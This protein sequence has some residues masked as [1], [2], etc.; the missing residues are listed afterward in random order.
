MNSEVESLDINLYKFLSIDAHHFITH[1]KGTPRITL[2]ESSISLDESH[3]FPSGA[4]NLLGTF[5][6]AT[7]GTLSL[8]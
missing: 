5:S 7:N 1:K 3:L 8:C 6:N 2:V 4:H